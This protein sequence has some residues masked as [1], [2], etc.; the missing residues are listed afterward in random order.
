[1]SLQAVILVGG[2]G[3]RLRP[4]TADRPKPMLPLC[5]RPLLAYTF[6]HL[7]RHGVGR[8]VLSCG[9]LPTQIEEHFGA[10][11]DGLV[12]EYRVEAQPL[13]TGGAI[14][15]GAE[16]IEETFLALNGDSLRAADLDALIAFHR[17]HGARATILLT[18]VPD[19]TRYGLVRLADGGRVSGFLEKPRP[20]EID[21]D[22]INAGLYVLEPGVLDLVPP[23]KAVSIEREVF[24]R[25]VEE[26]T[27]YGLALPGYW[28][29]VGTPESYLQAHRDVLERNVETW[30]GDELGPAYV[31]VDP[32]ARVSPDARLVPPVLVG[33]DAVV[34][35]GARVGSLAVVGAGATVGARAVVEDAVVGA[36]ASIGAR[37]RVQ[38]S[39]VGED[40]VVGDDCEIHGLSVVGPRARLGEGNMLDHGLRISAGETLPPHSLAFS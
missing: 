9:Y 15:F 21:T 40:A 6:D 10:E 17:E 38:G 26:G 19:P 8:A 7:R 37:A 13:G 4:L 31:S 14:R 5:G 12:F 29:D 28:L 39:L 22:L 20:E 36:G 1:V 25:L 27:L 16:G 34:G 2:E 32:S 24:P 3:T 33:P 30:V 18:P 35:A 11:S 23:G